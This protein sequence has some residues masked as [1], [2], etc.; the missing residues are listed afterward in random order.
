MAGTT[1]MVS[2]NTIRPIAKTICIVVHTNASDKAHQLLMF[3]L[4]FLLLQVPKLY[5]G[6]NREHD[7][8]AGMC[9]P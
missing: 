3:L 2:G 8:D 9:L 5:P 6:H 7:D 4:L 1:V